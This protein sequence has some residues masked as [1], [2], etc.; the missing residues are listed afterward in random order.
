MFHSSL[1]KDFL[2][3]REAGNL[4]KSFFPSL[5]YI[6]PSNI[7]SLYLTEVQILAWLVVHGKC[8][9]C[10]L[11]Q[12]RKS[13]TS[14]LFIGVYHTNVPGNLLS[15]LLYS[16]GVDLVDPRKHYS[17]ISNFLLGKGFARDWSPCEIVLFW[18]FCERK[19]WEFF[20]IK[21]TL[22]HVRTTKFLFL[23][24]QASLGMNLPD[25]SVWYLI[26]KT[27]LVVDP[28]SIVFW[29]SILFS[30]YFCFR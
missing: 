12:K 17:L 19:L 5:L 8:N 11:L 2:L 7:L 15:T 1:I 13:Y 6:S 22:L 18:W 21:K 29:K 16:I 20:R 9:A 23:P 26:Q 24:F 3:A 25:C 30:K 10:D 27:G 14:F 4:L 28:F